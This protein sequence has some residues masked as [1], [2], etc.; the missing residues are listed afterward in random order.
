MSPQIRS[1]FLKNIVEKKQEEQTKSIENK[2]EVKENKT[3]K[4]PAVRQEKIPFTSQAPTGDWNDSRFQDGCEEASIAMVIR[5]VQGTTFS[6]PQDATQEIFDI[7]KFEDKTFG[8]HIDSSVDD[9][10]RIFS[11]HYGYED[12]VIKKDFTLEDLRS[13]LE[14]GNILLVPVFGQ[15]LKNPNFTPPGPI[16]HMLVV[17]G[18]DEKTKEFITNDPGTKRGDGYRYNEKILFDAIWAYPSGKNH[19]NP[20][21]STKQ[22]AMIVIISK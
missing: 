12:F 5:W 1:K 13:D 11:Q 22:K 16:A 2:V 20:P 21:I 14:K 10:G 18:W 8:H 6:S 4:A 15:A 19:S 9:A 7:A 3:D 17:V